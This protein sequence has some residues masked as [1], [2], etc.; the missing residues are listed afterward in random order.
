MICETPETYLLLDA[1]VLAGYY[2]HQTFNPSAMPAA[3]RIANIVDSVRNGCAPHLRLLTPEI[4]VAEAQTVLS[5]HAN[6]TW[7]GKKKGDHKQAIHG[8]TYKKIRETLA[9]D[10]HGGRLIESIPLQRYHVLAKH[11]ITPVD[12][13][14]PILKQDGGHTNELGGTDQLICGTAI[15]LHRFLGPGRL[16]VLTVDYRLWKVLNKAAKVKQDRAKKLGMIEVAEEK[17][18]CGWTEDIYPQAVHLAKATDNQLRKLL[19]AWPLPVKKAKTGKNTRREVTAKDVDRLVELYKAM[20][21]GRDRL[22]YTGDMK[23]LTKQFNDTTG[24]E[25]TESEVWSLLLVG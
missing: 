15:W 17:I 14:T 8:K 6:P 18:G 3:D 11:L 10:L 16:A 23:R 7:K 22:P 5:K 19:G 24:H 9:L 20:G 2:A 25:A 21:I 4:C 12:H 13:S 1:N